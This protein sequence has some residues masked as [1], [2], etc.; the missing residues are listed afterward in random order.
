MMIWR[1]VVPAGTEQADSSTLVLAGSV[2]VDEGCA[3]R[4]GVGWGRGQ[5][6]RGSAHASKATG[7]CWKLEQCAAGTLV[8]LGTVS[9]AELTKGMLPPHVPGSPQLFRLGCWKGQ[10]LRCSCRS[11]GGGQPARRA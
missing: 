3:N 7:H 2:M 8:L 9:V 6:R 11:Q 4:K 10:P 5:Q 1:K